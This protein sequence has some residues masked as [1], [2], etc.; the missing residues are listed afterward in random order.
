MPAEIPIHELT[1]PKALGW[2]QQHWCLSYA[3]RKVLLRL[4]ATV[5]KRLLAG[6]ALLGYGFLTGGA[7]LPSRT[8]SW[9]CS[10]DRST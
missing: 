8:Y 5:G 6:Y 1:D 3:P 4:Q 10:H 2:L 9:C 7:P